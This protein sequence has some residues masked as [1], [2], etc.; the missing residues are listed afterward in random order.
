VGVATSGGKKRIAIIGNEGKIK[1]AH[2]K[3]P[4]KLFEECGDN[5][6]NLAFWSAISRHIGG[7]SA[8]YISWNFDADQVRREY[9]VVVFAAANQLNP[10]WDLGGLASNLERCQKP[11]VVIGLGAQAP[12]Y[13]TKVELQPGTARLL[14]VFSERCVRIGMRGY[15]SAEVAAS[16]GAKNLAVIGCPSN[17][18]NPSERDLGKTVESRLNAIVRPYRLALNF[19]LNWH[20]RPLILQSVKWL[21]EW[22]GFLITQGPL[23]AI[24]LAF[25]QS[26]NLSEGDLQMY[27]RL[28][29]DRAYDEE[30]RRFLLTQFVSLFDV[31]SWIN[32]LR[33]C[34]VSFGTR[35]HGNIL[36]L[37]AGVPNFIIPHDARTRELAETIGMA[38]VERDVIENSGSL[39]AVLKLVAFDGEV[40]DRRRVELATEYVSLLRDSGLEVSQDL[41][42]LLTLADEKTSVGQESISDLY[43]GTSQ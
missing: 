20:L 27:S 10:A 30:A 7:V 4:K 18:L 39:Q 5:T 19:D 3:S 34:R 1:N 8:D 37:Q 42:Q 9:D 32:S 2:L 22:G 29:L 13:S 11:L 40:Y 28:L 14:H 41:A 17:F 33:G 6:G 16:Y 15:F 24:Y 35:L 36:A 23:S 26:E 25:A 31:E 38:I 12:D 21:K 43:L